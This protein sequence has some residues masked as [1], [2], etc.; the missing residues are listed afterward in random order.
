MMAI[1]SFKNRS[2]RGSVAVIAAV[3]MLALLGF[4]GMSV[5]VGYLQWTRVRVQAAAD[6][7]VQSALIEAENGASDVTSAG[8]AASALNGFT[9][10]T[11]VTNG[12]TVAINQPPTMGTL[13][14]ESNA[15]EAIVTAP[16]ST[17]FMGMFGVNYVNIVARA[18]GSYP[19]SG[20]SGSSGSS[21][22]SM[23]CVYVLNPSGNGS[24]NTGF[25]VQGTSP[26]FNCGVI[27]ESTNEDA[28]YL[29]GAETVTMGTNYTLGVVGPS[30]CK[31]S[32]PATQTNCG[33][34]FTSNQDY[35][36]VTGTTGS[37][38]TGSKEPTANGIASPGDPLSNVSAPSYAS[39]TFISKSQTN[40]NNNNVPASNTIKPGIYCGGLT[41]QNT[42]GSTY[43]FA[44]G[45]Y[46]IAGGQLS[47]TGP[48]TITG[49]GVTF[50]MT[51]PKDVATTT[52]TS[53]SSNATS[54]T[55]AQL[56]I[57]GSST[58]VTLSAPGSSA[59]SGISGML[60]FE[61]RSNTTDSQPSIEGN[62]NT[63]LTGA[64]YF[65]NSTLTYS[66]VNTGATDYTM[67]VVNNLVVNGSSPITVYNTGNPISSSTVTTGTAVEIEE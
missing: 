66:G 5:D 42:G 59:T 2:Q 23:G 67:I 10:T 33:I 31:A 53:C 38:C 30:S 14:G 63:T 60:F 3:S 44:A 57:Q 47:I 13:K 51:S 6:A 35:V 18:A 58:Y 27:V 17:Y 26:T 9:N 61:N 28:V 12:V 32:Q 39:T 34:D 49:T 56:Q 48:G 36:C 20:S 40:Y 29:S 22:S 7:A 65:K 11:G 37:N 54:T 52:G 21:S 24:S 19:S 62:S 41:I 25:A 43:N 45:T 64:L 46:I 8:Q 55:V 15:V 4:T 50:Y 1:R 16:T